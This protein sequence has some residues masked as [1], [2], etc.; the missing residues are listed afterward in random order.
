MSI[1]VNAACRGLLVLPDVYFPGWKVP[2]NDR[3]ARIYP[4]DGAFRSVVVPAGASR[5]EF[6]YEPRVFSIG[7][8]LAV[9]G[10]VAFGVA[11]SIAWWRGRDGVSSA[12][13]TNGA[14]AV[15]ASSGTV[16]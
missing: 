1:L 10:L 14:V 2:V 15:P 7:I 6:R 4:T 5:V 11:A 13:S 8:G 12:G 3:E 9:A 16:S